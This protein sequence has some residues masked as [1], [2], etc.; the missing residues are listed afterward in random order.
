MNKRIIFL[1]CIMGIITLLS[2]CSSSQNL[3]MLQFNIW[4]EGSMI[5]GGFDAI[6]DEIARLE[7]DFI[8]L[9]EVRN[10]RD[11]RFCDRIVN[12]LKERGKTYYSFYSYDTGLL[13]KHPI[14]DSLTVFPEK[15]DHG[16]I[17]RLTSSVNGHKVAVYTS[18]LDY[19]DCAYYNVRGYDGS[20]WKEIPL[21]ASVEEILKVNV[22]SQRDDAIRLFITQAEKDLAAGYKV[23]IGG[24]FNE[25]SHRDWIEKNKDMYDHNGF[26]VPWTVTTLLEE[27]GFV[28][29]YRKIYPNPLTHPGFTYPSDNPAKTPEKITWAPKADERDRIDFIF[30]KGEGL[31]ARKAV[32][33]G[34][35][36]SIVRAQRVQETSKD[37]FLLPLDVWPTDHKGLLV[38][39]ICK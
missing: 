3:S 9:S 5:P 4:Q 20:T 2:S 31:D 38:T 19:L 16:S 22:A 21:P 7:P 17:Y 24:D 29:S 27:A 25:P 33:F 34:P 26:V 23:I 6:A 28:D 35:K 1:G 30:Y 36:G 8:M 11:T 39:F 13:S 15:D 37:K 32:I 18:H 10:Y 12:A 14:T